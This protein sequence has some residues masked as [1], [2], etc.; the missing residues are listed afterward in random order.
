MGTMRVTGRLQGTGATDVKLV[1]RPENHGPDFDVN[2]K[3]EDVDLRKMNDLLMATAKFDVASGALTVFSEASVKNGQIQGYVKPLFKDLKVY[4]KEKDADKT[5][6]QKVKEKAIDV[7]GKILKNHP[8]KEV[9]TVVPIAGPVENP[10][11]GTWPTI[12]GLLKNAFFKALLPGFE[13]ESEHAQVAKKGGGGE[14]AAP[15][16]ILKK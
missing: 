4:E 2:A 7:A 12:A 15:R 5:F 13:R 9:A 3:V 1:M 14:S 10:Q 16:E 8:R 6:G 11:A